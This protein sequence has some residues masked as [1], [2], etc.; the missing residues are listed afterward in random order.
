MDHD[1]EE[2]P[3]PR[4]RGGTR[5]TTRHPD[6]DDKD[7]PGPRRR[8]GTRTMRGLDNKEQVPGL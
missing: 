6:H 5:T 4:R 8:G 3:G 1:D 2:G 7:A